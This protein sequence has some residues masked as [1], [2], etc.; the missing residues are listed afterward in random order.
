MRDY[1]GWVES[2]NFTVHDLIAT[3]NNNNPRFC[4]NNVEEMIKKIK[5]IY[6]Q[7]E[8]VLFVGLLLVCNAPLLILDL[9][10]VV[11]NQASRHDGQ[12]DR[13]PGVVVLAEPELD[14]AE[15]GVQQV[16][17]Q[18]R[19]YQRAAHLSHLLRVVE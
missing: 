19:H 5:K 15:D 9:A 7:V 17:H 11:L 18:V 3:I 4:Q 2:R 10:G 1:K 8:I 12:V 13:G 16:E 6:V 14:H